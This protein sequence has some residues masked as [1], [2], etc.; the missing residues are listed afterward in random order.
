MATPK[1]TSTR[2][3]GPGEVQLD[4]RT[5]AEATS[6]SVSVA[7]NSTA[8]RTMKK[9][10]AGRSSGPV[11]CTIR[12]ANAVPKAG[13]EGDFLEKCVADV[14]VTVTVIVGGKRLA[15][16]GWITSFDAEYSVG[17]SAGATFTVM[18]GKPRRL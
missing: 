14:D 7:P 10:L 15:F 3:E 9:G 8:V 11:E 17:S 2:Y 5:L 4:G 16:D 12:V 13:F 18:A 6:V 1:Q